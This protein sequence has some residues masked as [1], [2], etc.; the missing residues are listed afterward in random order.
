MATLSAND[1]K[2]SGLEAIRM[3]NF[4]SPRI[5]NEEFAEWTSEYITDHNRVT[6]HRDI[7]VH[8]PNHRRFAHITNEWYEDGDH[9]IH[10]CEGAADPNCANQFFFTNVR[11]H[12][13]YLTLHVGCA[14]VTNTTTTTTT[15]V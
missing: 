6:H 14:A 15:T 1:F 11:D 13:E 4:G 9:E 10:A 7:V 8:L 5:G 2:A 12:M 3:F